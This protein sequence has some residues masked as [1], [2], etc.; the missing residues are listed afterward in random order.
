[1]TTTGK[2]CNCPMCECNLN[3]HTSMNGD[4][5]PQSGDVTICVNCGVMLT[6]TDNLNLELLSDEAIRA[7][8]PET[9]SII[10]QMQEKILR[11]ARRQHS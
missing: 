9:L 10:L 3:A 11:R 4:Y 2:P 1:M 6:F 5:T 7:V 8:P